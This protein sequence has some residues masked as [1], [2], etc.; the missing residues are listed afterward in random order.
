MAHDAN[1]ARD[2]R[3]TTNLTVEAVEKS[4]MATVPAFPGLGLSVS[5]LTPDHHADLLAFRSEIFA[6]LPDPDLVL[7]EPDE[8]GY[9]T[10]LL[11]PPNVVIGLCRRDTGQLMGYGSIVFP[12]SDSDLAALSGI[13]ADY[14]R[15]S[16]EIAS[17]MLHKEVRGHRLQRAFLSVRERIAW[18]AGKSYLQVMTS[19]K[20]GPS[21]HNLLV[22]GYVLDWA[23][24]VPD[25]ERVRLILAKDLLAKRREAPRPAHSVPRVGMDMNSRTARLQ[26]LRPDDSLRVAVTDDEGLT[27]ALNAGWVSFVDDWKAGQ[28]VF[29]RPPHWS[30]TSVRVRPSLA[31]L[32]ADALVD[33]R[34][35]AS[36]HILHHAA[37]DLAACAGDAL[38]RLLVLAA[39]AGVV[40]VIAQLLGNPRLPADAIHVAVAASAVSGQDVALRYLLEHGGSVRAPFEGRPAGALIEATR[41]GHSVVVELLLKYGA[42][43]PAFEFPELSAAKA[44]APQSLSFA[45][46]LALHHAV[47]SAVPR[48]GNQI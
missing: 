46:S 36:E 10:K 43:P 12:A 25:P 17:C 27:T 5:Y 41:L 20:N 21:R 3:M 13:A 39:R 14:W 19:P 4:F 16:A 22:A 33:Q 34:F 8:A 1:A 35:Y 29:Y 30:G 47:V 45:A 32:L 42:K 23:G 15:R 31:E 48:V 24:K 7:P 37:D 11:K 18:A 28:L 38:Q 2:R 9:V 44:I 6:G 26:I 40:D